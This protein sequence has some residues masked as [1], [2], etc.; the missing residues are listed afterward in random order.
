MNSGRWEPVKLDEPSGRTE[1][2]GPRAKT[3][4]HKRAAVGGSK[5]GRGLGRKGPKK[6]PRRPQEAKIRGN[7][8]KGRGKPGKAGYIAIKTERLPDGRTKRILKGKSTGL[9]LEEI[10]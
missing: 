4:A 1:G 10:E 8:G 6:A 5:E 9:I 7:E 2:K 3:L